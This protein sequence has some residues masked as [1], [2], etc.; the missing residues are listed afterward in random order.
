MSQT[1]FEHREI[2]KFTSFSFC[3]QSLIHVVKTCHSSCS[4]V[5]TPMWLEEKKEMHILKLYFSQIPS[6][7]RNTAYGFN[8]KGNKHGLKATEISC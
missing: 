3:I 1:D 6:T 7:F 5:E 2:L 4:P 8:F